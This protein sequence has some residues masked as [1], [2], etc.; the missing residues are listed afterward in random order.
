MA[1]GT[2]YFIADLAPK[3]ILDLKHIR[4]HPGLYAQNC[5][6]RNYPAQANNSW[7]I[8][9]LFAQLQASQKTARS[10]RERNNELRKLIAHA[11]SNAPGVE[12]GSPTEAR[13][14]A[15]EEAKALKAQLSIVEDEEKACQREIDALALELPNLSSTHT[16]SGSDP[17]VLEYINTHPAQHGTPSDRVWRSHVH[18]GSA[19][20]LVDFAGA[21]T[22][23]G[24]GWYVLKNEAV[25]LE[26][27]LVQFALKTARN[28][29]WDL[30]AP[31]SV[32]YAHI[33]A[34]C[35]FMPRD[36]NGETQIYAL[37]QPEK[38]AAKPQLV[39][40]GTGE[41]PIA[42]MHA[43]ST[44][45]P[46][47]LP[48]R[49][50]GASRCFRAEA[51]ARGVDTKGLY[52]VHEFTKVEMFAF[53]GAAE[54]MFDEMLG[55]QKEIIGKLGLHGRVL[56]MPHSELGASAARKIDIEV[57]FPS[58]VEKGEGWGEVSSL[59]LCG[60]YQSRRLGTRVRMGGSRGLE[61]PTTLNG[62]ALAVPRV[63]A[64]VLENG[65]DEHRQCVVL[66]ECLWPWMDGVK[67][68][69][70]PEGARLVEDGDD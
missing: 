62:T 58:R 26:H 55:I 32:V 4:A 16:P 8:L 64:A 28:R 52:R 10:L 1:F 65:W 36:Q 42:G 27:A 5:L 49:L 19:L 9:E 7:R 33:A 63:V 31:Q 18:I 51:G 69:H 40:A 6:D 39:L 15:L 30:V 66:P 24:W 38:D 43:N 53:T 25:Q 47:D 17:T 45:E 13:A 54:Q 20:R 34:A 67:E 37:E 60:D 41:I 3:P 46:E 22:A 21:A 35:G 14:A 44:F 2:E 23:S 50:V 59:S 56:E 61:F 68:I 11:A 70:A 12:P 48:R 57:F 29:G